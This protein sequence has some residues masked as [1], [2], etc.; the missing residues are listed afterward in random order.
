MHSL[1]RKLG[2]GIATAALATTSLSA[3]ASGLPCFEEAEMQSARI[4]DLRVKLMVSALKCRQLSPQTLR[5]Y[6]RLLD[7]R[8]DELGFHSQ[9]VR[10]TLVARHGL[11]DG[12]YAFDDYETRIGNMHSGVR[13]SRELCG[14]TDA[15]IRLA[16]RADQS[17]LET[18]S[19]LVTNR[20]IDRC[21]IARAAP[22]PVP[23]PAVTEP[24]APS[25]TEYEMVDGIPTYTAPGTAPDTQ[26]EPLE[27]ADL[28]TPAT[29]AAPAPAA[30]RQEERLARA[31][32]A[33]DAAANALRDMQTGS[34]GP[35]E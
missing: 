27:T 16:Q 8:S 14:D 34:D 31:I 35:T 2:C 21:L 24:T 19:K 30:D 22:F 3:Q 5:T 20:A 15:F 29:A 26:P 13:P 4:H 1:F 17:E 33:L 12:Q 11:R 7:D 28:E 18:L 9:Q 23:A 10:N 32:D 25:A 6:G